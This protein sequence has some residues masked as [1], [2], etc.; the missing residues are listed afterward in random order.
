MVNFG[1]IKFIEAELGITVLCDEQF[2]QVHH[3]QS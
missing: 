1:V 2:K 3:V